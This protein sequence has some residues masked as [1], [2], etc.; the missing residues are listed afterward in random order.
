MDRLI[1]DAEDIWGRLTGGNYIDTKKITGITKAEIIK[2]IKHQLRE[3]RVPEKK[4]GSIKTLL[5]NDFADIA[6][7]NESIRSEIVNDNVKFIQFEQR[8]KTRFAVIQRKGDA[9]DSKRK[10]P[11]FLASSGD[12]DTLRA[13]LEEKGYAFVNPQTFQ[14]RARRPVKTKY[15]RRFTKKYGEDAFRNTR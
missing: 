13:R 12:P 1:N 15:P 6:S 8:G 10:P 11:I 14:E 2:Q 3:S 9:I 5:R 7:E 4:S